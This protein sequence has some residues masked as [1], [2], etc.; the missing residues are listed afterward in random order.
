M[1]IFPPFERLLLPL[2]RRFVA[3]WVRPSVLPDDIAAG[4]TPGLAL[5]RLL[6]PSGATVAPVLLQIDA[7]PPSIAAARGP[8]GAGVDAAHPVGAGDVITLV[9][10][11]FTEPNTELGAGAVQ[12]RAGGALQKVES[13]KLAQPGLWEVAFVLTNAGSGAAQNVTVGMATRVSAP[14]ALAIRAAQ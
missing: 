7:A 5:V 8:D 12:V 2:V 9:V 1:R 4:L 14:W 3:L 13:V 6:P 11:G 10:T